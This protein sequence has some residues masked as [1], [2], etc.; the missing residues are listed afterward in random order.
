MLST[1]PPQFVNGTGLPT[2]PVFVPD[3]A[4]AADQWFGSTADPTS[5]IASAAAVPMFLVLAVVGLVPLFFYMEN[6]DREA[7]ISDR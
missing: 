2:N 1:T 4:V 6:L 7:A 3:L 5:S